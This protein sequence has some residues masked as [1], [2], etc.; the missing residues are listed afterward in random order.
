[1]SVSR[2]EQRT[3]GSVSAG[4]AA[5]E[6]AGL[7]RERAR[8]LRALASLAGGQ[9]G[10]VALLALS[11]LLLPRGVADQKALSYYGAQTTTVAP[12]TLAF[13]SAALGTQ[14]AL[15]LLPAR[16]GPLRRLRGALRAIL[17]LLLAVLAT[18]YTGESA[19]DWLHLTFAATLFTSATVLALWLAARVLCDWPTRALTAIQVAAGLL[20]LLSES[21]SVHL[22]A[23]GELLFV[24]AFGLL[25]IRSLAQLLASAPDPSLHVVHAAGLT[26]GGPRD[27][28]LPQAISNS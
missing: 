13:L 7:G 14:R 10:L 17:I 4:S 18:P 12:Y 22:L 1:M 21:N 15:R 25:L 16:S 24:L 23:A 8:A 28:R 5:L 9:L 2:L 6:L 19:L 20:V 3:P 11:V 26:P 27:G